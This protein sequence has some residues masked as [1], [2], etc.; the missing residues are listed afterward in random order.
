AVDGDVTVKVTDAAG[1][2]VA[3]KLSVDA[4][5]GTW[6][7]TPDANW[8]E[9]DYTITATITDTAGNSATDTQV[10]TIDTTID[11]DGDNATVSIESMTDDTG[12]SA[13][14]IPWRA[15]PRSGSRTSYIRFEDRNIFT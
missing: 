12:S 8:A 10:M 4:T 14:P 13:S 6:T 11:S 15:S 5:N 1:K 9:G 7:F 3:G 2:P